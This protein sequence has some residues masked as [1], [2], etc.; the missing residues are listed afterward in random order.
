MPLA[1]KSLGRTDESWLIQVAV[2]LKVLETH[3]ANLSQAGVVE[4]THLQ[5][6]VKLN[7]TEIDSLFLAV[8]DGPE[9]RRTNALVTCEAKQQ[10][11]PILG[12]QVIEQVASAY[13]SVKNLDLKIESVIPIALKALRDRAAIYVAEFEPWTA[14]E[15]AVPE[16][17]RK[18]LVVSC[19]AVYRLTPPVPGIGFTPRKP[20]KVGKTPGL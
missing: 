10:K 5:T 17:E 2:Q 6:G 13:A 11:D 12:S 7:R 9:G 19:S 8:T 16:A 1:T 3:F 4:L 20:Q 15:A 14:E 18:D